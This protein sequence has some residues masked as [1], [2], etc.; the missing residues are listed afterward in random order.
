MIVATDTISLRL[1]NGCTDLD[2]V[3]FAAGLHEQMGSGAYD[4]CSTLPIPDHIGG[5][6]SSHRTARK[7]SAHSRSLGYVG[8]SIRDRGPYADDI[9]EINTS[10][11]ERQ[12]R[13]MSPGYR[14]RPSGKSETPSACRLHG[15]HPYGV[16]SKGKLCAYLWMYRAGELALVSSILG[17]ANHEPNDVMYELF[18]TALCAEV[19]VGPGVVVYNRQDSGTDGLRYFK[20]RLGFAGTDVEWLL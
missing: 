15:V 20:T 5:W 18:H 13:P 11:P 12:G 16:F 2:C 1:L 7:R 19:A 6:T 8:M 4:H 17:H 10:K 14:E 3:V 9:Y